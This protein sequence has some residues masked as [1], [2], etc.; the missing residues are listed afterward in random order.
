KL[1]NENVELE[2]Q[3]L[4]YARENA[5]LK[6]TYKNL[7]DSISVSRV[8]TETKIASLQNELQSNIYKCP[9]LR[10][11]LFKKVS[12][13]KDNT[14]D[15]SKNTKFAKQPNVEILSK[16]VETNALSKPVTSNSVS[17][18]QVS[19]GV[20]NAKVISPGM[21][22][23]SPDKVSR[24]A[25]KVPNTVSASSRTKPITVSQPNVITKKNMNSDLNGLSSTGL[26]NT[27][28]RRPQ[29]RSNT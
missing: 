14:Q 18:P 9:K 8:Q 17:T 25:K 21:F 16:I 19:K 5:H 29:P 4:N 12:D 28:T 15:S 2:F 11:Q 6:A 24:E 7:F 23:I 3:V 26:D 22:R 20:N 27:K 13:Q 1:E 10:T